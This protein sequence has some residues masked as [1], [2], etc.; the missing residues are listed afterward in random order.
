MIDDKFDCLTYDDVLLMPQYSDIM[1]RS[2]IDTSIKLSD[3]VPA[4]LSMPIVSSPMDTVTA[5]EM[6]IAMHEAGG[7]GII[8]RGCP[9]D[10]QVDEISK[11][12]LACPDLLVGAAVGATGDYVERSLAVYDAGCRVICIDV[13]HGHHIHVK[14]AIAKLRSLFNDVHIMTGNVASRAAFD[15]VADWGAHSIRVSVGA[16]AACS[17]RTVTGHGAPGISSILDSAASSRDALLIADGGMRSSGDIVKALAAGADLVMLG[18][19][20]AGCYEA[21]GWDYINPGDRKGLHMSTKRFRGMA[22]SAANIDRGGDGFY[23]EGIETHIKASGS[24]KDIMLSIRAGLTSGMS[25]SGART[26]SDFRAKA[27]FI[28]QTHASQIEGH[29]RLG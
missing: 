9:I 25:Y 6:A 28:R 26:L 23:T 8:H 11:A 24:S 22:S 4:L 21:S 14:N 20:L 10:A 17:T 15:D 27:M 18:R 2:D 16:G 13:A 19:M 3:P 1:S 12:F 29:P 7:F 5:S